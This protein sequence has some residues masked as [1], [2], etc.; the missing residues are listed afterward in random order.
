MSPS[1]SDMVGCSIL[2]A[3]AAPPVPSLLLLGVVEECNRPLQFA[4]R[5]LYPSASITQK[6]ACCLS[7]PI[8]FWS[9]ITW[10]DENYYIKCLKLYYAVLI[11]W[12]R[13]PCIHTFIISSTF[14][15]LREQ[16]PWWSI[17][18]IRGQNLK[19]T[20]HSAHQTK[21]IPLYTISIGNSEVVCW[22]WVK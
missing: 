20:N 22:I 3:L 6:S 2:L 14:L 9:E 13:V 17:T 4:W 1:W 12:V 18:V 21:Q 10:S 16:L 19:T 8:H 7:T 5:S 11:K 15:T